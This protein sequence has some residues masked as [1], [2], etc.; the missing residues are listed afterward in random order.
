MKIKSY[1]LS[2]LFI[3]LFAFPSF[4]EKY[5][6][7]YLFNDNP[8]SFTLERENDG[9][10]TEF[11][12]VVHKFERPLFENRQYLILGQLSQYSKFVG[13]YV[14]FIDKLSKSFHGYTIT[15]PNYKKSKSGFIEGKC[16]IHF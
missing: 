8:R 16:I 13:Y 6:C 11:S 15:E 9:S 7:S 2:T 12:D 5:I 14:V 4:S 1:I 3:S 10:F